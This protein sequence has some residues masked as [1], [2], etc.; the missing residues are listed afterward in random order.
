MDL[1]VVIV[2]YNTREMLRACLCALPAAAE[3]LE[4]ETFVV[5]NASPDDSAGMVAAEFPQVHLIANTDN[6]GFARAN[7]QALALSKGRYV[8]ALNPD[9]EA[10][11]G[12][13]T[14]LVRFMEAHPEAGACGPKL[15]NSDGSLQHNGRRFPTPWR[16][17]LGVSGLRNLNRAAFDRVLEYGRDNF[18][19]ECEVDQVSGAC[20]L[21]RR[22]VME[23]VGM[24]DEDFFMFYE[25]IEW[26]WRIRRA[27]WKVY[28]VPQARVVHHWMGSVRQQSRAMTARLFR[29]QLIYY[30]KTAGL[31][32]RLAM[33]G[34]MLMG[35]IKNELLYLG[36]AI[37]RRLRAAGL[38][39]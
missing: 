35:L 2:S 4:F 30:Q 26:C 24:F 21:V 34:V 22:A 1:S 33:R 16:E 18:D 10:E 25:E 36:V 29:S 15:L 8:L 3:G 31:P 6:P 20:L 12:S 13:L 14:A 28:Y 7:N 23:Q 9:T 17:F 39:K 19:V 11:P 27:G 5:D 38:V 37:K 32:A